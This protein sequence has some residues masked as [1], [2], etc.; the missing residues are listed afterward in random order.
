[1][2][3]LARVRPDV[4]EVAALIDTHFRLMR[5]QSPPESCHVLPA[6][7][8]S[9]E[10]IHLFAL[11]ENGQVMAV[12]ALQDH[13]YYGEI[14]SMHTAASARGRGYGRQMLRALLHTA[15]T[16]GLEH[17]A[18]ETGSAEVFAS[19]RGLY[20]SEGFSECPPFGSYTEDPLSVF[21]KRAL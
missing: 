4:P 6:D 16:L 14:K 5:S 8:L 1:M 11:S 19:A 7:A 9:D 2:P 13:G 17:V 20:R 21:Y 12:G 18:L 10:S 3:S 15:S